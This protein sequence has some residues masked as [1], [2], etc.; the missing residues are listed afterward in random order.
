MEVLTAATTNGVVAEPTETVYMWMTRL[1]GHRVMSEA[2]AYRL[3]EER[4]IVTKIKHL[5]AAL[6][7]LDGPIVP[8]P[9]IRRSYKDSSDFVS[10]KSERTDPPRPSAISGRGSMR[11]SV[12]GTLR[13]FGA[14]HQP[15][16]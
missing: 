8:E 13:P 12:A 7:V 10:A 3:V 11:P 9:V 16:H 5:I 1:L 14:R 4:L 6:K 15:S 2:D